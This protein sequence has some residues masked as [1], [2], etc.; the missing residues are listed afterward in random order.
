MSLFITNFVSNFVS[1]EFFKNFL[2][3]FGATVLGVLLGLPLA[4]WT[5]RMISARIEKSKRIEEI[6]SLDR[7]LVSVVESL[8]FNRQCFSKMLNTL[9]NN[10]VTI[11]PALDYSTWDAVQRDIIQYLDDPSLQREIAYYFS[12]IRT[13][14]QIQSM[15]LD[16]TNGI[17][18]SLWD[19]PPLR[20]SLQTLLPKMI[21]E[22]DERA[23]TL[24]KDIELIRKR[25]I[26]QLPKRPTQ[27][28]HSNR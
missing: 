12:R 28:L 15:Y 9:S 13:L 14:L 11:D 25:Y 7:A 27:V 17:T 20:Q 18:A 22:L 16:S 2:P 6:A 24:M 8:I 19:P 3:N 1:S 5:N 4:L 10:Q 21:A 23:D 26:K